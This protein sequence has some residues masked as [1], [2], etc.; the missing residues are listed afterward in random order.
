MKTLIQAS[1]ES[2]VK[3]LKYKTYLYQHVRQQEIELVFELKELPSKHI[4][5]VNQLHLVA[6]D[7][8]TGTFIYLAEIKPGATAEWVVEDSQFN[9]ETEKFVELCIE[10]MEAQNPTT[11]Y[12]AGQILQSIATSEFLKIHGTFIY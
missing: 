5:D 3:E 6:V 2:I 7:N 4:P 10:L 11:P 9:A 1:C 8:K 12:H